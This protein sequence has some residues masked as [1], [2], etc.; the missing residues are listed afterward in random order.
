VPCISFG[1]EITLDHRG[2]A[3]RQLIP[4]KQTPRE[5][6]GLSVRWVAALLFLVA[7]VLPQPAA[8]FSDPDD[9][10][11][12]ATPFGN[13]L[14]EGGR[15]PGAPGAPGLAPD[16]PPVITI[17]YGDRQLFG[18]RGH[19]QRWVNILGNVAD[20]DGIKSLVYSL[21]GGPQVTLSIGPDGRRLVKAGDFNVD[22]AYEDLN[23]GLNEVVI[24]ATDNR[25]E[26]AVKTV[27]VEYVA[28]P[29]WQ[30][31]YSIDWSGE[32]DIQDVAQVVDGLWTLGSDGVRTAQPGY[33]R[34]I[35][36]GDVEWA[37][38]EVTVPIT[39]HTVRNSSAG[40]GVL[41]RWTGHTDDPVSG[42]Q[43]KT[44]WRPYG[45][46]CWYRWFSSTDS[47]ALQI[48]SNSGRI[49]DQTT[50][51]RL[52]SGVSYIF[53]MRIATNPGQ[54]SVYSFKVWRAG[55][56]EPSAWDL[57]GQAAT[58]DPQSGSFLLLAH[59][60]DATFGD[61]TAYP[62]SDEYSLTVNVDGQG[63]VTK[64]PDQELY[65]YGER[66]TLT[67][68]P[69]SNWVFD[70]WS[71][72]LSGS[73]NPATVAMTRHRLIRALFVPEEHTLAVSILPD[74][75]AGRVDHRPGNPYYHDTEARLEPIPEPGWSFAA[76][77]GTDV[78]DLRDNEDGTWSLTMDDDKAV[79]ATFT[80]DEYEVAVS[81]EGDGTVE[82]TPGNPYSYNQEAI[83]KPVPDAGSSFAGWSGT[84]AAD[85]DDQGDG[86]WSLI[87][88]QDK[89]VTAMFIRDEYSLAVVSAPSDEAGEV[90]HTP[91]NPY[92][93]GAVA[94]LEPI[95]A[96]GWEFAE[97][98][99]PV[100]AKLSDNG[101]GSW[102]VLVERDLELT[103]MFEPGQYD[104]NVSVAGRGSVE[105]SPGNPYQYNEVAT[106]KPVPSSGWRFGGWSGQ[107]AA[108]LS[109]NLNGSWSIRVNGA[110]FLKATFVA[111]QVFLPLVTQVE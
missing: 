69:E 23:N 24:T 89:S 58:S 18:D 42:W 60:V 100:G 74:R 56:S 90:T 77:G 27:I 96:P 94:T 104:V 2:L 14:P 72:D 3:M 6:S 73:E 52:E 28:G 40:V 64:D 20:S 30:N 62:L 111:Y 37:D 86:T 78:G 63:Q 103:A 33:D 26:K 9:W 71:G 48:M 83:L 108:G 10:E 61:V 1:Y 82:H 93:Y 102:M 66:I 22:L 25:D 13:D 44:G 99:S 15:L 54:G 21:N 87:V 57:T 32:S 47:E 11:F 29:I 110:K 34:L 8:A 5:G 68:I 81:V 16:G 106:L 46:I 39:I 107:H 95:P 38:Y 85:M 43:P 45:A 4:H 105:N 67:A 17:W 19:P 75:E 49:L 92:S 76:W 50:S 88:D 53:K 12:A 79:T 109:D 97:W 84:D 55:Q 101:D 31:P 59:H 70:R 91:G 98:L 36:I 51:K 35:A 80:R 41:L 65:D 7:G